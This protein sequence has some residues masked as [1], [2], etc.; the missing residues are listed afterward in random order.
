MADPCAGLR[1]AARRLCL[2]TACTLNPRL[3][4][5]PRPDDDERRTTTTRGILIS[6]IINATPSVTLTLPASSQITPTPTTAAPTSASSSN[7]SSSPSNSFAPIRSS[8]ATADSQATATPTDAAAAGSGNGATNYLIIGLAIVSALILFGSGI[9]WWMRSAKRKAKHL[10]KQFALGSEA[11]AKP[12]SDFNSTKPVDSKE[13]PPPPPPPATETAQV[14]AVA[15]TTIPTQQQQYAPPTSQ[16]YYDPYAQQPQ[17]YSYGPPVPPQPM[18]AVPA[19]AMY[20]VQP[21]GY[22]GWT[23][24]YPVS[25]APDQ[26]A[27]LAAAP[28]PVPAHVPATQPPAAS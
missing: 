5:C 19:P 28:A 25:S 3:E 2:E 10:N 20:P 15:A 22:G 13:L 14:A 11:G 17:Y 8:T 23:P 6:P 21:A 4:D 7:P 9:S 1:G 27:P 18:Y 12:S 16:P 24:Q 26:Q